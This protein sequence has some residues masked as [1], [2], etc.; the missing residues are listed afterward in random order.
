MNSSLTR[1]RFLHTAALG[2][3]TVSAARTA[4]GASKSAAPRWTIGCLNRPWT[5]WSLDEMLDGVKGAGYRTLGLQTPTAADPF[6]AANASPKY[7]ATL[8]EKIAA[9]GL[10]A[11][12]GRVRT[13]EALPLADATSDIRRQLDNAQFLGLKAVI[14]TGTAKPE[15]YE[16]WYRQMAFAAAYGAD[17][18]IQVVTKPHGGVVAAAAEILVCLEKINHPNLGI[19][20]DAGNIIYYTGKDP[21]AELEPI[22]SRVTAFTAKDCAAKGSEVMIQFGKG[23]VDFAAI[24][25]RLKQAGFKGPI[26]VESC[27]IKATPAET[28]ANA[29]ANR[30]FLE[31]VMAGI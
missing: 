16:S 23:K 2:V 20:Y 8:K 21:M 24:F 12:Q 29:R 1:R 10:E 18:G 6:I 5:K 28:T 26:M 25:R 14:N 19:W 4:M 7:L 17:R 3:A 15:H 9:R 13:Q 30:E 22:I 11:I 31:N 27:E